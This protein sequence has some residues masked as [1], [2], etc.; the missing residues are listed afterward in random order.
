PASAAATKVRIWSRVS[1]SNMIYSIDRFEQDYGTYMDQPAWP[2]CMGQMLVR[3]RRRDRGR[4]R[5]A[6]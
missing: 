2:L 5:L 6:A 4:R 1:A 3:H